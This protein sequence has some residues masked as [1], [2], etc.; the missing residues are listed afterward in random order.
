MNYATT[1]VTRVSS[2]K[3]AG[4]PSAREL[5]VYEL[6]VS[7]RDGVTRRLDEFQDGAV[8]IGES[9]VKYCVI[10]ILLIVAGLVVYHTAHEL[11]AGKQAFALSITDAVSGALC[12]II[13]VDVLQTIVADDKELQLQP[14]I[15]IGIISAVREILS[16]GAHL[17]LQGR[18]AAGS[19]HLAIT[20]LEVNAAVVL[21]LALALLLTR[22]LAG[23]SRTSWSVQR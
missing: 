16:A 1:A 8:S 12:A 13:I 6:N 5:P 2:S 11:L 15:T 7:M 9:L 14:F 18:G 22:C 4:V 17:S 10:G 21:G 19:I 3:L 20:E 23:G